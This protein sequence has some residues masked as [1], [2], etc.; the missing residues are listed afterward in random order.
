MSWL[1]LIVPVAG[2]LILA[3]VI[4]VAWVSIRARGT[5]PRSRVARPP[6]A[7]HRRPNPKTGSL[8]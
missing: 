4:A 6:A 1:V 5:M 8:H 7:H 2:V 3:G